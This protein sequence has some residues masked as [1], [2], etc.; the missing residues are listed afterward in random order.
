MQWRKIKQYKRI[1][2]LGKVVREGLSGEVRAENDDM[3]V[4]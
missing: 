4:S 1:E 3:K 2:S